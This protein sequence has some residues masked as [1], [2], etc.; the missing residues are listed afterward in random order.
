MAFASEV[1]SDCATLDS[2]LTS[3]PQGL[4]AGGGGMEIEEL[5]EAA[6]KGPKYVTMAEHYLQV[7][8]A[9]Y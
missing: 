1:S 4:I 7:S 6:A 3:S 5:M 9:I 8:T 2:W